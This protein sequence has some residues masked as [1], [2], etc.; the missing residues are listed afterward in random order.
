MGAWA[1]RIVGGAGTTLSGEFLLNVDCSYEG[2][3]GVW[4]FVS[5]CRG[6][7]ALCSGA[8]LGGFVPG[9]EYRFGLAR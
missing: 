2:T 7:A 3:P 8:A 4:G 6:S 1:F 5:A 9:T